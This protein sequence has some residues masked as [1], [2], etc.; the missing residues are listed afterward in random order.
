MPK[1][2][3]ECEECGFVKEIVHSMKEKLKDCEECD[4][5]DTLRRVPSFNL[6]LNTGDNSTA[7]DRVKEFI[8]DSRGEIKRERRELK[9]REYK[10]D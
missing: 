5:I 10:D 3:Y 7:G 6:M 8:E 9:S 1:Y 4:T 2:V